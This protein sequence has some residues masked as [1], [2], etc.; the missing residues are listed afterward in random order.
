[1]FAQALLPLLKTTATQSGKDVR[2]MVAHTFTLLDFLI[3]LP[4]PLFMP[5]DLC[6]S[7]SVLPHRLSSLEVSVVSM[8]V[9]TIR[10]VL[11][12]GSKTCATVS[13]REKWHYGLKILEDILLSVIKER[14][15]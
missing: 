7:V 11:G 1:M 14:R 9:T 4:N 3:M 13:G 2:I 15:K 6:Q 10:A 5:L 12:S 8:T